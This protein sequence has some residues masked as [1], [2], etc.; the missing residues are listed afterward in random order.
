M[1]LKDKVLV[2]EDEQNIS[3]F[4]STVLTA[5]DFDVLVAQTGAEAVSMITS[6]CPD[7]IILDLGLPDMDGM[8]ILKEV[9]KAVR[10]ER[11]ARAHPHGHPSHAHAA[12][13]QR[14]RA[15]GQVHRQGPDHRL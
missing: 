11:A 12:R 3:N 10:H 14:D 5:N 1:K 15:V 2:V 6:H 8:N 4:I 7:L 13:Q 9:R